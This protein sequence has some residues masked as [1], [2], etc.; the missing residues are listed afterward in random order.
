MNTGQMLLSIGGFLL[1]GNL[2][3]N[4]NRANTERMVASYSNEAII[5]ASGLAQS[6]IDEIQMKAFDEKT[7]IA[8]VSNADSLTNANSLGPETGEINNTDFDDVDDY[9]NYNTVVTL[10]R[11][12]DFNMSVSVSYVN[13]LNPSVKSSVPTFSKH[14][15]IKLTNSN[16]LDTLTFHQIIAY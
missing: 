14:I 7:V 3:I 6:V 4:V 11:M 9:K 8:S 13:T 1:L 16:I 5:N 2:I 12:G 10:D 15:E